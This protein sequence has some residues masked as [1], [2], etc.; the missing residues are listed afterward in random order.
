MKY[1]KHPIGMTMQFPVADQTKV[2]VPLYNSP[3][4]WISPGF[5][6]DIFTDGRNPMAPGSPPSRWFDD[7]PTADGRKVI[8]SDTDHYSSMK[9]NAL[10]AWKSLLRGHNPIL[11]DLGIINGVNPPDPSAGS[12][13]YESHEATR[14][15]LGDT[16]RFAKKM[17]L[18]AMEPRGE[19]SSTGYVL[20]NPGKEYLVLE[21]SETAEPFTVTLA[22][23]TYIVEW[24]SVNGRETKNANKLT[25]K[26]EGTIRF[27]APFAGPSVVYLMQVGR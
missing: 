5:D 10:W 11:Y 23:G 1:T 18:I 25:V 26:L 19:L 14:Y 24:F 22:A 16:L 6:D 17:N 27:T 12:P 20:A 8:L 2:N 9:S 21:P 15:A 4:D 13:S 7:P 3:A